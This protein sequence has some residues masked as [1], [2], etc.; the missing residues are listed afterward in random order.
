MKRKRSDLISSRINEAPNFYFENGL[1]KVKPYYFEYATFAKE[2]WVGKHLLEMFSTEF[3]DRGKLYYGTA[4]EA[5]LIKVN[6]EKTDVDYEIQANDVISHLIHRHEPPVVEDEVKIIYEDSEMIVVDKPASMPV[7][8]SGRYHHNTVVG[9]LKH[10]KGFTHMS[11]INR[12]DRLTSGIVM[13]SKSNTSA[14]KMHGKMENG[15]FHKE[16][17]CK[18]EGDFPEN[19][20]VCE[21]PIKTVSFKLGLNAVAKDGKQCKTRFKKVLYDGSCS[22]LMAYPETGRTH[23]I[24]VHLQHLGFPIVNDPLYNNGTAWAEKKVGEALGKEDLEKVVA[25]F[26]QMNES[27]DETCAPEDASLLAVS[28]CTDCAKPKQDPPKESLYL[29][30]HAF[31]YK[32][33]DF[34]YKSDLPHWAKVLD[35][36]KL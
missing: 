10:E 2:R 4:I 17:I 34:E 3:K 8:P 6:S 9:I 1:R 7:H 25:R 18:V 29:C 14:S 20:T 21:E 19:L 24:R 12:I 5:G 28:S 26:T 31:R 15:E 32:G 22:Y 33:E 36:N 23:Q 13:L 16:Y 35:P 30:L 27:D 11:V